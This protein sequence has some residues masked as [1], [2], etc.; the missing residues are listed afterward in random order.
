MKAT[1]VIKRDHKAI[2]D[3]FKKFEAASSEERADM[4]GKFF[5]MLAA[6]E[7][8][9]DR[10]FYPA[11]DGKLDDNVVLNELEAEQKKLHLEA[12]TIRLMVGVRD[13]A[14]LAAMDTIIGHAKKEEELLFPLVEEV[15]S[16]EELESI[17]N[18]M[19]PHSAVE[20]ADD[21]LIETAKNIAS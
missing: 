5:N 1:D 11:L 18:E 10:H 15:L 8:M 2:E 12:G 4:E 6:H 19:A 3:M 20:A 7:L 9:E 16:E 21:S 17:G 13:K 14:L